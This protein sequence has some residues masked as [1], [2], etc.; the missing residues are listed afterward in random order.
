MG[1]D[2][3]EEGIWDQIMFVNCVEFELYSDGRGEPLKG[4]QH[5]HNFFLENICVKKWIRGHK[6][7][8]RDTDEGPLRSFSNIR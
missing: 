5:S 3:A 7:R 4:K 8:G 6:T 2:E 1:N